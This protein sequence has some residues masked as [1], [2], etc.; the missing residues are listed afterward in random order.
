MLFGPFLGGS[1]Y[2]KNLRPVKPEKT[3][4]EHKNPQLLYLSRPLKVKLQAGRVEKQPKTAIFL[5]K[6]ADNHA[7]LGFFGV[8]GAR[9]GLQETHNM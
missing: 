7:F 3:F 4:R 9:V 8:C 5:L 1:R 6:T 2:K